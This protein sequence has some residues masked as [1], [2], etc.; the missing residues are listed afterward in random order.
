MAVKFYVNVRIDLYT[1]RTVTM[2]AR[3]TSMPPPNATSTTSTNVFPAAPVV[4]VSAVAVPIVAIPSSARSAAT[5]SAASTAASAALNLPA[6]QAESPHALATRAEQLPEKASAALQ[7][8]AR[9]PRARGVNLRA[10]RDIVWDRMVNQEAV[11]G[12]TRGQEPAQACAS[13]KRQ[14]GPFVKCVVVQGKLSGACTN[15]HYGSGSRR[16]SFREYFL[17]VSCISNCLQVKTYLQAP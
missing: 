14:A 10:G 3:A 4:A 7:A 8:L 15:C 2:P 5:T 1:L 6:L 11:L 9:Q 17:T 12:Y 16:C 13:C